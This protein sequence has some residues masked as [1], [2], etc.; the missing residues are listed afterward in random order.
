MILALLGWLAGGSALAA[1][2]SVVLT[3]GAVVL[4]LFYRRYLGI[5]GANRRVRAERQAYDDLRTSLVQ[6]NSAARL[7]VQWLTRSLDAVDRF[8]W[9]AGTVG[10]RAFGLKTPAPLWTVP[11]FYRCLL[12]A[13][14]YPIVTI[15]L[16]WTISGHVGP[17]EAALHLRS[18]LNPWWRWFSAAALVFSAVAL[19]GVTRSSGW[20]RTACGLA[21]AGA[22]AASIAFGISVYGGMSPPRSD[23]VRA[24]NGGLT[25][26]TYLAVAPPF[27]AA[28]IGAVIF[29]VAVALIAVLLG[30]L[31]LWS[32]RREH[33]LHGILLLFSVILM[34]LVCAIAPMLLSRFAYW[35]IVGPLLLFVGLLTL[36]NAPFDWTSLGLTRALMRR[37]LELR[38]WCPYALALLDAVI[39][40]V[41]IA[42]LTLTMVIGVQAFDA[43]AVRG[44]GAP[45]LPLEP[46]FNGIAAN[47]SAPEYWWIYALLLST[48]I[49]SLTNLV[50]GGTSLVRGLPR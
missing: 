22:F 6:G 20:K 35:R 46:L 40:S 18:Y 37:G 26:P 10:Q 43:S 4:G 34:I 16:V 11:A 27:S 13:L 12:L 42:V 38:S 28:L 23:C 24:A 2:T 41:V 17:G 49:P 8:F 5:L 32:Q 1:L 36:L 29:S 25:C 39:A 33:Q 50:I 19:W 44:G 3:V 47:P 45:V 14:I 15:V 21:C 48:M 31:R 7:Y 9:D 30:V